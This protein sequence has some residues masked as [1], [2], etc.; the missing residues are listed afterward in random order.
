MNW[1]ARVRRITGKT[2]H[3]VGGVVEG[4]VVPVE[5]MPP[6]SWVEIVEENGNYTLFRYGAA[7]EFAGD[8]WHETVADAKKQA[9]FEY[10][11]LDSDWEPLSGP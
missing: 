10:E 9:A 3:S 11:I 5:P 7:G 8:P 1:K 4:Q 6:A 2:T